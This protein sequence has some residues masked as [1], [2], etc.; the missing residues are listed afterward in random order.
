[1]L[2]R[3]ELTK[4]TTALRA[5]PEQQIIGR[6]TSDGK[7]GF[8]CLGKLC[9][10][11][12][13]I[14]IRPQL[15]RTPEYQGCTVSLPNSINLGH[16]DGNFEALGMPDLKEYQ[17]AA[18]ANDNGATWLEIADH[19]DEYYPCSDEICVKPIDN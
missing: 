18:S 9:Q 19:F 5:N 6:L 10:V 15:E 1:M 7:T 4:W 17:T 8:C 14:A 12:G 11:M 2:T 13:L 16:P 3:A